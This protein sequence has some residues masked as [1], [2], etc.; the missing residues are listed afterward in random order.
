MSTPLLRRQQSGAVWELRLFTNSN[1]RGHLEKRYFSPE[2]AAIASGI[3][4]RLLS[5][6]SAR[7]RRVG[8]VRRRG[9]IEF[10][11][12][13]ACFAHYAEKRFT[14]HAVRDRRFNCP[15]PPI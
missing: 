12:L 6:A 3:D 14:W 13:A 10:V 5:F 2:Q 7:R 15:P 1:Q 4:R 8:T 11:K 9:W